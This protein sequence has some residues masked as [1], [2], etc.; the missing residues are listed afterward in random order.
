MS[1]AHGFAEIAAQDRPDILAFRVTGALDKEGIH[2]LAERA[3]DWMDALPGKGSLLLI[4]E[5][6]EADDLPSGTFD[7]EMLKARFKSLRKLENYVV[8]NAP[9]SA[10]T[11]VEAFGKVLPL[12]AKS[13]DTSAEAWA[14]LGARPA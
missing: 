1:L 9:G 4:F 8:A 5:A 6:A 7:G 3:N 10:G 13:F 14:F 11:M 12:E 2:A